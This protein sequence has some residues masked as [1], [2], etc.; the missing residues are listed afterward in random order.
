MAMDKYAIDYP[1]EEEEEDFPGPEERPPVA[2]D[3]GVW[4]CLCNTV[5]WIARFAC[6]DR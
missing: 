5:C 6:S 2:R 1:D 4:D 3:A